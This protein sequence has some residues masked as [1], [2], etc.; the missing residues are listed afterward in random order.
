MI[1]IPAFKSHL[2]PVPVNGEGVLLLS[3][4]GASALHGSIYDRV[5]PLID[6]IRSADA[7]V[8]ALSG[9]L[10]AAKVYYALAL[11]EKNGH[12]AEATPDSAPEAAAFWHGI[13]VDPRIARQAMASARLRVSAV[14]GA[15]VSPLLTALK[16]FGISGADA[17]EADLT[18]VVASDYLDDEL[19]AIDQRA[20][21]TGRRWML[22]RPMGFDIWLGP[23]FVPGE[24]GCLT[25]LRHKLTRHRVVHRF[26][27]ARSEGS[28]APLAWVPGST[29]AA[30][31]LAAIEVAKILA[32]VAE[33]LKGKVV[34]LDVRN[35]GSRVH[36]LIRH[37]ACPACGA[38]PSPVAAPVILENRKVTFVQDGGHRTVSPEATLKK[39]ERLVS[40]I[41][42]VV[43]TLLPTRAAEGIAHVY[44]AGHNTALRFERLDHLKK[45]LRNGS[46]GKGV[47]EVQAKASALCEAL[48]RYSGETDGS[49][50]RIPGKFREMRGRHGDAVI[51][52]NTVMGY[53]ERQ[54]AER[55]LWMA[56]KSKF[57]VVPCPF[58][59]DA[60]IDWTPIWS[61]TEERYKY[62]PTQLLYYR[63]KAGNDNEDFYCMGCSNG[64][65]S[66][67]T[68][69][70]AVLQGFCELVE[71][72]A[73]ALWWYNCLKRPGVDI[74]AFGEPWLS[75][76][77]AHYKT[78]GRQVWAL[79]I[80]SDLGIP[81]FAAFS[82]LR[83][84][85]EERLL[86]GLGCHL[87]ARIALQRA[88]AEMNQMLGMAQGDGETGK[89]TVE[90]DETV[91]WL[92]TATRA[93]QPYVVPDEA[94]ALRRR[95]D[96]PVTHS[97]DLLRD[98]LE[99][100]RRVEARG[101]EVMVLDQTRP[102]VGMPVVKVVVPGLR[103]F[104][105]RFAPGRLYDV[106]VAMGWLDAPTREEDL[107]PIPVFF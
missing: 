17:E 81:V 24:T 11:L 57:N 104:W 36:E 94:V 69:E 85:S 67:N 13:G 34:S 80:T 55:E 30:S 100:R 23:L 103:H 1:N 48:E 6:G 70:E 64:N 88:F 66:G 46:A 68:L 83:T 41:T 22:F 106:P 40:P 19:L 9:Q 47:S 90:D 89:L 26:A 84:G 49:E 28:T 53:S 86:F 50:L 73:T 71:R 51:H 95:A 76:L 62:L 37:P 20:R 16:E 77:A 4:D 25:C 99:C 21:E 45:G 96:Y 82:C 65:A 42:G 32:G 74:G 91:F 78:L 107:N 75:D 54:Y 8:A 5:V 7:I 35:W 15:D 10:D 52:P 58:D 12:L 3:E 60:A 105:A 33:G 29:R 63:A 92:K 18:V 72:D 38:A 102:D 61:L 93:N 59:E 97:G 39:Y 14:N 31:E 101:L 27:A 2:R 98:I 44:V 56:R 79:D 87:D 43:H